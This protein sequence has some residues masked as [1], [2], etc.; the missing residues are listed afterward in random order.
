MIAPAKAR[1]GA[2]LSDDVAP[3]IAIPDTTTVPSATAPMSPC[4]DPVASRGGG[5]RSGY[6]LSGS[7]VLYCDAA[8]QNGPES[9]RQSLVSPRANRA[10]CVSRLLTS[11]V[12]TCDMQ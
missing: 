6:G 3:K 8:A 12:V 9:E 1:I 2:V 10:A 7:S 11:S 4:S 5:T